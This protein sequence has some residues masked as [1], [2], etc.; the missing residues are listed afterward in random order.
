MLSEKTSVQV[1]SSG[2]VL[3][4]VKPVR[5]PQPVFRVFVFWAIFVR[6]NHGFRFA[7]KAF[8]TLLK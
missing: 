2:P 8:G 4:F 3:P 6:S 1:C 7:L 5:L